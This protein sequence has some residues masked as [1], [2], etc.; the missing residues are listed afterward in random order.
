MGNEIYC[1]Q[2]SP[3]GEYE[4][5]HKSMHTLVDSFV[6]ADTDSK[7]FPFKL[8]SNKTRVY[9]CKTQNERA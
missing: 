9:F 8:I 6:V 4:S 5:K 3:T 7:L 1:Y 2:K